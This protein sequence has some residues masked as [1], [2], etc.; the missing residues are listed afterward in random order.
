MVRES[1][2]RENEAGYDKALE[3]MEMFINKN[4]WV[5]NYPYGSYNTELVEYVKQRGAKL[6]VT[7]EPRVAD[8]SRDDVYLLP[9]LDCNDYPP[10][11]ENYLNY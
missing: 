1:A 2:G 11:S 4:T 9:R 10:K 5:M 8:L 7:T 6:G 3:V